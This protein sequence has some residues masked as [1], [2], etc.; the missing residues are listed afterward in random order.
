MW[1]RCKASDSEYTLCVDDCNL[2]GYYTRFF[3]TSKRANL[4]VKY[5]FIQLHWTC[6]WTDDF[7]YI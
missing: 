2:Q 5:I 3:F 1:Q 4:F 7:V 6:I